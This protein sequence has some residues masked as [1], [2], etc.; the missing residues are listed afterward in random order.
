MAHS[1]ITS[2]LSPPSLTGIVL[3][4]PLS[5]RCY[6]SIAHIPMAVW[7]LGMTGS[8]R[9]GCR[10]T[11][12]WRHPEPEAGGRLKLIMVFRPVIA[13]CSGSRSFSQ[14]TLRPVGRSALTLARGKPIGC[15]QICCGELTIEPLPTS[16]GW[17]CPPSWHSRS[18]SPVR[19]FK[20]PPQ[21]AAPPSDAQ[22]RVS[23]YTRVIL[24]SC[25][26]ICI[27]RIFLFYMCIL[28]LYDGWSL[29]QKERDIP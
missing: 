23:A 22:Y 4:E 25:C 3:D 5:G 16:C 26:F 28:L 19:P 8:E 2:I 1:G 10:Q 20:T 24:Y 12:A 9:P 6:R 29:L 11:H 14:R 13:A 15:T 27:L 21:T 17:T 7:R 18:L